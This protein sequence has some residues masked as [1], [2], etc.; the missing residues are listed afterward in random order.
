MNEQDSEPLAARLARIPA[1][2]LP[3]AFDED[4]TA[5]LQEWLENT[6]GSA[7][8][9]LN[10]NVTT[11]INRAIGN[12]SKFLLDLFV[13]VVSLFF[14]LKQGEEWFR[15]LREALPISPRLRNLI[16]ERFTRTFRAIVYGVLIGAAIEAAL[17]TLGFAF[18][19]IPLPIFFGVVTFFILLVPFIGPPLVWI[20]AT[21][22]LWLVE[23]D[24]MQAVGFGL[25]GGLVVVVLGSLIKP[26][27][28]GSQ[29][30]LPIFC[31]FLSILGGIIAFGAV[32]IVLGPILLA[33]ALSMA[34]I[35]REI[36]VTRRA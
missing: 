9:S 6:S 13:A 28:I 4:A 12:A 16:V 34:R 29:A 20:P 36:A 33:I 26:A 10:R 21:L 17:M 1:T 11:W 7:I 2:I 27:I 14:L 24:P 5:Q 32:G 19:G 8:T 23:K 25:Y 30:R 31:V 35:Y 15:Q 18:F 22:Y 3:A